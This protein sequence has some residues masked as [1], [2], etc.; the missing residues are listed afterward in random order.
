MISRRTFLQSLTTV[1]AA[2][3]LPA[4]R[5]ARREGM[6]LS[7]FEDAAGHQY[8]GGIALA[9]GEVF[10]ARVPVRAHGCA[11]HQGDGTRILF[12]ARRPGTVAFELDLKTKHVTA[13]FETRA[14]QHLSGHG[15]FSADGDVL[16]T[17]E[18]DYERKRGVISV[19]DA[20]TY[21]VINEIDTR[22]LDPHEIAWL[23]GK[24]SLLVANGGIMTHPRTFRRKLNIDTMDP[25]LSVIDAQNGECLEQW[26]LP[27]HLLSI[28][29]V[30][31]ASDGSAALGLQFE[32]SRAEASNV[33][34]LYRP[35]RGITLLECPASARPK[36]NGYVASVCVNEEADLIAASCPYG[37]GIA[38]WSKQS[39][40]FLGFVS[41]T[42]AYGVSRTADGSMYASQ[43]DGSVL[44][45]SKTGLRSHFIKVVVTKPI[46]WDDHWVAVA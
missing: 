27:E 1:G 40:D 44:S 17:P 12:F 37:S 24:R 4:C 29:H 3:L 19:R 7:G 5:T 28:R 36:L 20:R 14:G 32:G 6:L 34:A 11:I 30:S 9:E 33:V 23:P 21:R 31:I 10:G 35:M 41:A 26:R 39:G 2:T 18:H 42:E 46:R 8:I 15:V 22:G 38:C 13:A 43:R 25:S 45:I 16:F